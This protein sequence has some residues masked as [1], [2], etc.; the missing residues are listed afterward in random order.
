MGVPCTAHLLPHAFIGLSWHDGVVPPAPAPVLM[1]HVTFGI[2]NGFL[3]LGSYPTVG[4]SNGDV[5]AW[6]A[7]PLMGRG[8]DAGYVVPHIST[9][10]FNTMQFLTT[11]MGESKIMFGSSSVK[12][13]CKN[14][15]WGEDVA[16]AGCCVFP[17]I[18]LSLNWGCNELI[19]TPTDL[20]G[21]PNTVF[22]GMSLADYV[23]GLIDIGMEVAF[24]VLS[25]AGGELLK[26]GGK[27]IFK[28][29]GDAG[30]DAAQEVGEK[31][32]K[33][34]WKK[35][36]GMP[37]ELT[38]KA[39][40]EAKD[41]AKKQAKLAASE[42]A[43]NA[44]RAARD[45]AGE[46]AER[47]RDRAIRKGLTDNA[48][49]QAA[50][51][52]RKK[53]IDKARKKAAFKAKWGSLIKGTGKGIW[54]GTKSATDKVYKESLKECVVE[55]FL[56]GVPSAIRGEGY[57]VSKWGKWIG[58]DEEEDEAT[59]DGGATPTFWWPD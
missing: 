56:A 47:A 14:W 15:L 6:G 37:D 19:P 2:V 39:A 43:S 55:P 51:Q 48:Q 45:A 27:K 46:A 32:Y 10:Q 28:K 35:L 18:P 9:V 42:A 49:D 33:K 25:E 50:R 36:K 31:W 1:P 7:I 41:A 44:A 40:K 24:A 38:G 23:T 4:H 21:A 30:Q 58:L 52:A 3:A 26:K 11:A 5:L 20:V 29:A 57:Y 12:L 8:T 54:E 34:A 16:D 13:P 53:V 59:V 17:Y 22:V